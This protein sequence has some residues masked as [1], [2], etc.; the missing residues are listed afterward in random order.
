MK[1]PGSLLFA[2]MCGH[3]FADFAFQ[4]DWIAKNK[5]RHA[6]PAG[7]DPKLHGPMQAIWPYVLSSHALIH[8]FFVA[9]LTGSTQLGL[10]EAFVHWITDFGKCEKWYGIH[11]DQA[12]HIGSKLLWV[13]LYVKGQP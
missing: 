4:T 9:V 1:D 11:T 8:G 5:N 13:Y 7:Y 10:A 2:L 3:A 6:I 12:I